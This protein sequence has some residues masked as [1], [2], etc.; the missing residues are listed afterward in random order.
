MDEGGNFLKKIW[1]CVGERVQ[2]VVW[3]PLR[4]SKLTF[5][6]LAPRRSKILFLGL[7]LVYEDIETGDVLISRYFFHR[8]TFTQTKLALV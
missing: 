5:R 6:V 3:F 2:Q 7:R 8:F 4:V 1:S